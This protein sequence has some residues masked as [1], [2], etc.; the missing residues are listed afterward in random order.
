M[1][2]N[3]GKNGEAA[4]AAVEIA[5]NLGIIGG[6]LARCVV[7]ETSGFRLGGGAG[8]GGG[9]RRDERKLRRPGVASFFRRRSGK[10][11]ERAVEPSFW[12]RAFDAWSRRAS[13]AAFEAAYFEELQ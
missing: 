12:R 5:K 13:S 7:A 11:G 3:C 4:G 1:L 10:A 6:M 8:T 2:E 9:R